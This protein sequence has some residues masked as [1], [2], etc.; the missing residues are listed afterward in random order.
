MW[1]LF[2]LLL[3]LLLLLFSLSE[4]TSQLSSRLLLLL[5]SSRGELPAEGLLRVA[6]DSR[7]GHVDLRDRGAHRALGVTVDVND[8]VSLRDEIA[9]GC[10]VISESASRGA[11]ST[12][13][14]TTEES[15][16]GL[17]ERDAVVGA[18]ARLE[19]VGPAPT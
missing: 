1:H 8:D 14:S 9:A 12:S 16:R 19:G 6:R 7:R 18:A 17:A 11:S 13:T 4:K 2:L 3:L 5:F 10:P 15:S